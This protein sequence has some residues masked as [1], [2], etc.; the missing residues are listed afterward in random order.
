MKSSLRLSNQLRKQNKTK[1]EKGQTTLSKSGY[2]M[3]WTDGSR[4]GV[5]TVQKF[6]R[7]KDGDFRP[8]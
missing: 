3:L 8:G 2:I 7:L 1:F 5:E 4:E 6:Y